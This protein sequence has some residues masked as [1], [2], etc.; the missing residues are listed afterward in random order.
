M[1][2]LGVACSAHDVHVRGCCCCAAVPAGFVLS[3]RFSPVK[4]VSYFDAQIVILE[5][6][7]HK[8][9]LTGGYKAI[10]HLHSGEPAPK[11]TSLPNP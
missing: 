2:H 4:V 9:I 5:L 10:L 7:E 6:M 11:C 3:S 8:P 1:S